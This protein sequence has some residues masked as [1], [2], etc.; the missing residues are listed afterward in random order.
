M[1]RIIMLSILMLV[2]TVSSFASSSWYMQPASQPAS[3]IDI[4]V[5]SAGIVGLICS[6]IVF[7][8]NGD[9]NKNGVVISTIIL[10]SMLLIVG[11][12]VGGTAIGLFASFVF[13]ALCLIGSFVG[14]LVSREQFIISTT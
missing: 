8:G 3:L 11:L 1:K 4:V 9:F 12:S 2:A 10:T 7:K 13:A 6:F 14:W 5:M